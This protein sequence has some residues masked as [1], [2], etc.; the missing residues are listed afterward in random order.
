[1][2]K[3]QYKMPW[4]ITNNNTYGFTN[5]NV[6]EAMQGD[7]TFYIEFKMNEQNNQ[8]NHTIFCR[9]GMHMGV[10]VKNQELITWDFWNNTG[11][12]N[13]NDIAFFVGKENINKRFLMIVSHNKEE[14]RF[15]CHLRCIDDENIP[16]VFQEKVYDGSLI[17]YS[18]TPYNFGIANYEHDLPDEHKAICEYSLY[19]TG[20]LTQVYT[21]QQIFDFLQT[22]KECK[23]ILKTSLPDAMF[24][25]NTNE[26]TRYKAYD[27]SGNCYNLEINVGLIKK[28][29]KY[30][31][32]ET[33][34]LNHINK[35]KE[36]I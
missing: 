6:W 19:K 17:D 21:D 15:R 12:N 3:I 4:F 11:A 36:I 7:F 28:I 10:F 27:N 16:T 32:H 25:V 13:F 26:L 9:P 29:F 33:I 8:N 24:L 18:D 20:L 35:E 1:M 23:R 31:E 22:N 34:N 30:S 2:L 5:K 14:Q